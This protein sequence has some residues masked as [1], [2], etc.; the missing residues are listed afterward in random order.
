M[1][2]TDP[3]ASG[4]ALSYAEVYFA[5]EDAEL[6]RYELAGNPRLVADL[7]A[8]R[9]GRV[10]DGVLQQIQASVLAP[11]AAEALGLQEGDIALGSCG[12]ARFARTPQMT[13]GG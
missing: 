13:R 2:R 3:A 8:E 10:V 11:A 4:A 12:Y 7:V 5:P 9:T 6:I 1:T